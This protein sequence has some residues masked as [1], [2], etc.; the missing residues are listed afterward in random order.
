MNY[1][2]SQIATRDLKLCETCQ[3]EPRLEDKF[4]RRCGARLD[5]ST[6]GKVGSPAQQPIHSISGALV[7]AVATGVA[8][9]S[10]QIHSLLARRVISALISFPIWLIIIL[11][12]PLD[13]YVT[14]RSVAR[15]P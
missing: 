11:L 3:Y 2:P 10:G 12:S 1:D 14:A 6:T 4:C 7:A 13:A 15:Q 8:N 5:G 9:N